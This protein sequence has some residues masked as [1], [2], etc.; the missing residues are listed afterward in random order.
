MGESWLQTP[1]S[2]SWFSAQEAGLWDGSGSRKGMALRTHWQWALDLQ[3]QLH[4]KVPA[5]HV[6]LGAGVSLRTPFILLTPVLTPWPLSSE[7]KQCPGSQECTS[8]QATDMYRGKSTYQVDSIYLLRKR[9]RAIMRREEERRKGIR[10][11]VEEWMCDG[12]EAGREKGTKRMKSE[13]GKLQN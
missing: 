2:Q 3:A 8:P 6:S 5:L 10:E 1:S 11:G 7:A 4:R 9:G 12:K 13:R